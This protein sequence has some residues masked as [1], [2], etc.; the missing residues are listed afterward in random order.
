MSEPIFTLAIAEDH[1][2]YKVTWN[3]SGEYP[4]FRTYLTLLEALNKAQR[5]ITEIIVNQRTPKKVAK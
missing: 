2:G 5:V 1:G 3:S 4:Q